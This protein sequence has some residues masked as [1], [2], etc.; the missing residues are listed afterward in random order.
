MK[1][2]FI[3]LIL[4]L[5]LPTTCIAGLWP[6]DW[7]PTST[8]SGG[9]NQTL[10]TRLAT[11]LVTSGITAKQDKVYTIKTP[12]TKAYTLV[13][14]DANCLIMADNASAQT[15]TIPGTTAVAIPVG[16]QVDVV[17]SGAGK[18]TFAGAGG[19]TVNSLLGNK[20]VGA[21]YVG[22]TLVKTDNATWYIFGNLQP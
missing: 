14:T 8:G 12:T 19:V 9:D 11:A 18:L 20:A 2:L 17:Q 6:G 13:L 10:I 16:G 7:L 4:L 1:K 15:Y 3:L 22:V 21:R 5:A